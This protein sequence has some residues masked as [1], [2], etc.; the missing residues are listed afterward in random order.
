MRVELHI[1]LKLRI[2]KGKTKKIDCSRARNCRRNNEKRNKIKYELICYLKKTNITSFF[3]PHPVLEVAQNGNF[4][5]MCT[6]VGDHVFKLR[7]MT[8]V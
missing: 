8:G 7:I 6:I 3:A 2:L 5:Y 4:S 1:R